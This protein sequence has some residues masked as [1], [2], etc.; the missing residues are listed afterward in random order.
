MEI[1][2]L[3]RIFAN[4]NDRVM[5]TIEKTYGKAHYNEDN[6]LVF[7]TLGETENGRC[8]KDVEARC[9]D[10]CYVPQVSEEFEDENGMI[11]LNEEYV[12][13]YTFNEVMAL[14]KDFAENEG[15]KI[16]GSQAEEIAIDVLSFVD[17][18]AIETYLLFDVDFEHYLKKN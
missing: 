5:T 10:I 6:K 14:V 12:S 13:S 2:F 7:V 1:P 3:F 4:G 18:C 16:N 11:D 8:Y 17:W 9:G 15:Y